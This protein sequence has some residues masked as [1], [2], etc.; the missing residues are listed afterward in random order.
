MICLEKASVQDAEEIYQLQI[1]SF[2]ALLNKYQDYDFNPGA[3]KIE[4]TLQRFS[5][6]RSDFYFICLGKIHIGALRVVHIP[7]VCNLKQIFILPEYQEKGYA[8]RAM[9]AVESLYPDAERW[10]LDTIFQE[11]KLCYLYEKMGYRK[12]GKIEA[13]KE[14]M[15]LVSYTKI[16]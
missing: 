13:I 16:K 11:E 5:D 9:V 1:D 7:R 8:Q 12:T 2:R 14:G 4:R 3:E 10:D 6:P 15:D